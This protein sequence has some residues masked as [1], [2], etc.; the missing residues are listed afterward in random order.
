MKLKSLHYLFSKKDKWG[1][2]L[3]SWASSELVNLDEFPSHVA[4]LI[5]E[6]WVFE[7]TYNNNVSIIGYSKWL[8]L[9]KETHKLKC[10][11]ERNYSE[12]KDLFRRLDSKKYDWGGILYFTYRFLLYFLFA[13]KLPKIN[14]LHN[15]DKYFCCEVIGELTGISYEMSTPSQVYLDLHKALK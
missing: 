12:I 14:K 9:N 2:N 1:A 8:E 11:K 15:K 7:S 10:I 13:L 3:I 5:N 6:K 4:L